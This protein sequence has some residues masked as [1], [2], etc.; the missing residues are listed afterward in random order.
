[1][2]NWINRQPVIASSI[3]IMTLLA[4]LPTFAKKES[5]EKYDG[6]QIFKHYCAS[7]HA[8]GGNRVN[9]SRPLAGS[10]KLANLAIL[11]S[12]LSA[13]PGHMPYYE[14]LVK[15]PKMLQALYDYCR[16]LK[17]ETRKEACAAP[18][19]LD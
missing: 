5:P 12:Y 11:K 14:E 10:G 16:T 19:A 15:N 8:N 6:A 17:V 1:V 13:P 4:I 9:E 2:F 7:C 18:L 3:V